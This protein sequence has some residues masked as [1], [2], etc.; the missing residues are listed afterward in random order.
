MRQI[1]G[2]LV[3]LSLLVVGSSAGAWGLADLNKTINQTNFTLDNA[4]SATLISLKYKAVLTNYH[5]IDRKITVEDRE[6]PSTD[7]TIKKVRREKRDDV[8]LAQKAYKG[9]EQ[10]GAAEYLAEIVAHKKRADLALLRLKADSIPHTIESTLLPDGSTV[11]RGSRVYIVGNPQMLDASVVEGVISSVTRMLEVPWAD[12]EKVPF[13]Q[14]S[15]GVTG[16]NSG[17]ALYDSEGRLIGV[18]AAGGRE[19]H[20]GFAITVEAIKAFL[21]EACYTAVWDSTAPP[22][23]KCLADKKAAAEKSKKGNG[24]SE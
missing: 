14:F 10:V 7:G 12:G 22:P 17:G 11:V 16:G 21:R 3:G 13:Y 18:P 9:P 2:T 4:C 1:I 24:P 19:A 15:G 6:E 20:L 8:T 23:E 5:C